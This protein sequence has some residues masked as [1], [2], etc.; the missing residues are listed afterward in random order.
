MHSFSF[1]MHKEGASLI[2]I[3]PLYTFIKKTDSSVSDVLT[4]HKPV[5]SLLINLISNTMKNTSI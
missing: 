3:H 5:Q 1:Y 2:T 4:Y